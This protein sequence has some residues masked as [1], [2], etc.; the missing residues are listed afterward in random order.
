MYYYLLFYYS[1]CVR[2]S[3]MVTLVTWSAEVIPH[4]SY[5]C[6][7]STIAPPNVRYEKGL[8]IDVSPCCPVNYSPALPALLS[9]PCP[10]MVHFLLPAASRPAPVISWLASP[11]FIFSPE[12]L[13]RFRLQHCTGLLR[14]VPAS[15]LP[16]VLHVVVFWG[17]RVCL[18][19]SDY[20]IRFCVRLFLFYKTTKTN[21][22]YICGY[23]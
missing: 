4:V 13:P 5:T 21:C 18:L 19:P 7:F 16:H 17:F 10:Y 1:F 9:S 3:Y 11:V 6:A 23:W 12:S 22:L 15:V 2:T 14:S 20:H 8:L